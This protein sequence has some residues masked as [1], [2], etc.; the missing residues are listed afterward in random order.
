M[1]I[2]GIALLAFIVGDF[3]QIIPS[4][5]N[6]YTIV[7]VG[8]TKIKASQGQNQYDIYYRQNVQLYRWM[9]PNWDQN[10]DDFDEF[11]HDMTW[12]Q[13]KQETLLDK[14]LKSVG[15]AFTKEMKEN[16]IT[17]LVNCLKQGYTNEAEYN[18]FV[19]ASRMVENGVPVQQ[20]IAFFQN[21]E[22][23]KESNPDLYNVYEAIQRQAI[24]AAKANTYFGMANNGIYFSQKLLAQM[25]KDNVE[26][27][28]TIAAINLND[29]AFDKLTFDISDKEAKQ[30]FKE[31]KDRYTL[32]QTVK[33]IDL[34]YFPVD[35]T[36]E[37]IAAANAKANEF[38]T[39]LTN[40]NSIAEFTQSKRRIENTDMVYSM[41]DAR[42]KSP[43]IYN[44][45]TA[46]F[47]QTDT[48][49]YLKPGE[50][51]FQKLHLLNRSTSYV[52]PMDPVLD[53]LLHPATITESNA[54]IAPRANQTNDF[55]YFGQVRDLQLRP[56]SIQYTFL[57]FD[58][59]TDNN[60]DAIYTK[61]RARAIADSL[62]L[63][64]DGDSTA[65]FNHLAT[66][67][68][69]DKDGKIDTTRRTEWMIDFPQDTITYNLF[70]HMIIASKNECCIEE[71]EG[72]I[73]LVQVL[74]KTEPILKSQ[75]VLFPVPMAPSAATTKSI[76]QQATNLATS[77][78]NVDDMNAKAKKLSNAQI[79]NATDITGMRGTISINNQVALHCR[80]A[81]SWAY[82][83]DKNADNEPG[84]VSS[85]FF[86]GKLVADISSQMSGR[87]NT[88][89]CD[90]YIVAGVRAHI[91]IKDPDFKMIKDRV[92]R[93]MKA[94]K[95]KE[96][97]E[98]QLKKELNGTNLEELAT[99]YN[100]MAQK[101]NIHFSEYQNYESSLV[102][103]LST[104]KAGSSA[105]VSGDQMVYLV[106]VENINTEYK[107]PAGNQAYNYFAHQ[108][109]LN[110]YVAA[111]G[112]YNMY[113]QSM[114][115]NY[116]IYSIVPQLAYND[117]EDN[118]KILDKRHNFYGNT[119]SNR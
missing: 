21:I 105:V 19:V 82:N 56:D 22:D 92:I 68:P 116:P 119:N 40:S 101:T 99:K 117:I 64:I 81:I 97:V 16:V 30:Y 70:N 76:A 48:L 88:V 54:F 2:I 5:S 78:E 4:I 118:T 79:I 24:L 18:L 80:Q 58:Y 100:S 60:K 93:D 112:Q 59:K 75:Y 49:L 69:K 115:V 36:P 52:Q 96:A 1:I 90:A 103:K 53:S 28:A 26:T 51:A 47:T 41:K 17:K 110:K 109:A 15:L 6:K 55:I 108:T 74:D 37:D 102:G 61:E 50:S 94:E 98:A 113:T 14:E 85:V 89:I 72:R 71:M 27:N 32:R 73:A 86:K 46:F 83:E 67:G 39:D 91:E 13:I 111:F 38:F 11:I 57:A 45:K 107:H 3:T 65:M 34:V 87:Q 95:K 12:S 62:K 33:D 25:E 20:V 77:S 8:S 10:G 106:K 104:L 29:P 114:N 63:L 23:Y 66:Y 43:Y 31:H 7:R 42:N 9:A 84:K 35:A 44:N